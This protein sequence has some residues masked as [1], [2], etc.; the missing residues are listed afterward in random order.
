MSCD[1]RVRLA[2]FGLSCFGEH[3]DNIHA[4]F[5][6]SGSTTV[7]TRC[8]MPPEAFKGI[9]ST[10]TDV[11]SFGM[12]GNVVH[13]VTLLCAPYGIDIIPGIIRGGDGIASLLFKQETRSGHLLVCYDFGKILNL[14]LFLGDIFETN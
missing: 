10:R 3:L 13:H 2:D 9:F 11:Y 14:C 5:L 7:G 6:E 4:S 12:V 8:Y 1:R